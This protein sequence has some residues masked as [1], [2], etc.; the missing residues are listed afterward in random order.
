MS[1]TALPAPAVAGE[2]RHLS[3]WLGATAV[4]VALAVALRLLGNEYGWYAGYF[5]LQYVVLAAAWNILGGYA[6][7]VN[8]GAAGFMA[9]GSYTA[10]VL[11]ESMGLGVIP[12]I[13]G[14]AV[15][16]GLL[17][18]GTGYLTLRLRGVYF[19]IA[20]LCLAVV[21]QTLIVNWDYVGGS[22]GAYIIRPMTV[23]GFAS[24]GEYIFIV[25]LVLAV[26]AVGIGRTVEMSRLGTGLQ[27]IRDNERAAE[28]V[29]V[30][31]LRLKLIAC[32]LSGALMG[33]AGAPLPFYAGY[34]N[35]EGAFNLAYA[36]N[37]IAMP[38]I[39][40]AGTWLGPV[41]GAVL[42]AT[43]QQAATVTI[44]SALNLWIVGWMLVIFV[45]LFP[46]GII[47]WFRNR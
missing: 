2:R 40:G 18:L 38:L 6:G 46:R 36:V 17:G 10:I 31:T 37:S 13:L 45:A 28:A 34:I 33:V 12:G 25:M 32:T 11:Y 14:G 43:L 5:V 26:L 3:Y 39:G 1:A 30:P 35:P 16:A 8:F 7:Y 22:R 19:S 24:Y 21:L 4:A 42:L 41:I 15:V 47:G 29:G 23:P 27:A 20:T 9:A 44:S